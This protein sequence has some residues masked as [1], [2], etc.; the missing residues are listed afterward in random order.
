MS[1]H[2]RLRGVAET[3]AAANLC[4]AQLPL[5]QEADRL[6]ASGNAAGAIAGYVAAA[7]GGCGSATLDAAVN[8]VIA[9]S[10]RPSWTW[11]AVAAGVALGTGILIGRATKRGRK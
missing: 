4:T 8:N 6:A 10:T 5:I 3:L 11:L 2:F 7:R 9:A 1:Q